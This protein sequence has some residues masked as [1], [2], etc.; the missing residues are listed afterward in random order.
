MQ[1]RDSIT[2]LR[3]SAGPPPL[4][5]APPTQGF[6]L[7]GLAG[8][9]PCH[10]H[11]GSSSLLPLAAQFLTG[12]LPPGFVRAPRVP[13]PPVWVGSCVTGQAEAPALS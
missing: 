3:S 5:D 6:H 12:S 13:P 8:T 1:G 2:S 11:L 7:A 9:S 10:G 4:K